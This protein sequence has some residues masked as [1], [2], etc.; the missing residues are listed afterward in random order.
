MISAVLPVK[1]LRKLLHGTNLRRKDRHREHGDEVA[2]VG[3]R[4]DDRRPPPPRLHET[5]HPPRGFLGGGL[6]H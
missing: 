4:D 5:V 2:G 1:T 3:D 6:P